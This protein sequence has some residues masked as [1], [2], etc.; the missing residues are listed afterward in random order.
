MFT[1][2]IE[3]VGT[4]TRI[5]GV[6]RG[7][8]LVIEARAVTVG[9][10]SG[11][12]VAVDGVCLTAVQVQGNELVTEV[13]PETIAC[14][15]LVFYQIGT[16]VNLERPLVANAR[17]GGHFVQGHVDGTTRRTSNREEGDFVRMGFAMPAGLAPFMVSKGSVAIN[18]VSLTIASLRPDSF[19]VQLIPHTLQHTNLNSAKRAETMNVE[20]DIIGKYVA[21]LLREQLGMSPTEVRGDA[22][23]AAELLGR[24]RFIEPVGDK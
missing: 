7:S 8:R 12:S 20:V 9:L 10:Q 23:P 18:G 1:G 22:G 5:D 24:R 16:E 21:S 2:L 15:N 13:S 4:V 3:E 17:L 19:E 6:A 11:D 14:S